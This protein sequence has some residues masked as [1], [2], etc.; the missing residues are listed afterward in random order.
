MKVLFLSKV[1]YP[2]TSLAEYDFK[3]E[4]LSI[5]PSL[6]KQKLFPLIPK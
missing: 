1:V 3:S 5:Y 4:A 2:H 6:L